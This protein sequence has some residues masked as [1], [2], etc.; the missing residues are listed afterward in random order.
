MSED[1]IAGWLHLCNGHEIGQ[2]WE[3]VRDREA[4]LSAVGRVTKSRIRLATE[5]QQS[6]GGGG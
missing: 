3:V 5:Q 4:W 2:T 6:W 1:E